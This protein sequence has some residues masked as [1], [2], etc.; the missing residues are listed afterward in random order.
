[1]SLGLFGFSGLLRVLVIGMIGWALAPWTAIGQ[2]SEG[3]TLGE[4]L[5]VIWI[6]IDDMSPDFGCNGNPYVHTPNVDALAARGLNFAHHYVS[7]PVCSPVRSA[8]ITGCHATTIGSHQHR[9][10]VDLPA[11][12]QPLPVILRENGY[13]SVRLPVQ[14]VNHQQYLGGDQTPGRIALANGGLKT[15][16]NF[17][18]EGQRQQALYDEWDPARADEP[19]FAMIDFSP[20]KRPVP[21]ARVWA[22]ARDCSVDAEA[23]EL[24]PFWPDTPEMRER[25]A[26]YLE[27][28]S[29]LDDQIG[30]VLT[31]LDDEGLADRTVV[32]IWSDHGLAFLR[33]KQWC[34]DTGLRTP[35]IVA[36]P[37]IDAAVREDLVSS[38]DLAP[39]TLSLCGIDRPIWMEGSNFLDPA[40]RRSHVF[41]SRDRCDETEER[42]RAVRDE[43]F[44]LIWNL[45]PDLSYLG[46]NHYTMRSF[47][48]EAE[49]FRRAASGELTSE[50]AT[51]LRSTK[52]V[53]ELFDCEADPLELHNLAEDPL[54]TEDL[55]RLQRLLL[56]WVAE[57]DANNPFPEAMATI[58]PD[59][60]HQAVI[61]ARAAA[62]SGVAEL[63]IP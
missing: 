23:I 6:T 63:D 60:A 14:R 7:T 50:Q 44:K 10:T 29:Y 37:G 43:R 8:L 35:L 61:R 39:T 26:T 47:S 31:W 49:L 56:A 46:R 24:S 34:Y 54:Y 45:R 33:H 9:S 57:T 18:R 41:A 53:W 3:E 4:R 13:R 58:S 38:I 42:I 22:A 21:Q 11:P 20:Q 55:R 15:D 17:W 62:N 16:F 51:M 27:A 5:N 12:Y 48:E 36:G 2:V 19:F 52:P 25:Y 59:S 40:E 30:R 1:M 32:M 28:V